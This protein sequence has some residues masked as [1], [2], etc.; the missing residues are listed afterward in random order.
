MTDTCIKHN[1]HSTVFEKMKLMHTLLV[2]YFRREQTTSSRTSFALDLN[3]HHSTIFP[4]KLTVSLL[5]L[6][7]S[8]GRVVSLVSFITEYR[9]R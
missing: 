9:S 2:D 5:A 8:P 6:I 3:L 4:S 7:H 1:M